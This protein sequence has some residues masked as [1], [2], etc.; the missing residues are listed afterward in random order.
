MENITKIHGQQTVWENQVCVMNSVSNQ[1]CTFY[2][3]QLEDWESHSRQR[4]HV[5]SDN[6]WLLVTLASEAAMLACK[7]N[8]NVYLVAL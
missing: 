5:F 2:A 4:L 8:E 6:K 3:L 1:G 7:K